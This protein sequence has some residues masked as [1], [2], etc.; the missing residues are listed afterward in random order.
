ML[1]NRLVILIVIGLLTL[2]MGWQGLN[3][4]LSYNNMAML[5]SSDSSVIVYNKFKEYFGED[6]SVFVI[7]VTNKD[8][9]RVDQLNAW[10]DLTNDISK[11]DGIEELL[12]LPEL[13]TWLR[14]TV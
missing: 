5:P 6:G 4:K 2:I 8:M 10:F 3:V 13:P 1:R 14:M 12:L 11:I 7:G 9:F